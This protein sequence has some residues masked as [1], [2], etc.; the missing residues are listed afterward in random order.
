MPLV[1]PAPRATD[2]LMYI[3]AREVEAGSHKLRTHSEFT[4]WHEG[5]ETN[6]PCYDMDSAAGQSTRPPLMYYGTSRA[7]V[8]PSAGYTA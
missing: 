6:Q 2:A 5:F 8:Y 4:P 7:V 3:K 1:G